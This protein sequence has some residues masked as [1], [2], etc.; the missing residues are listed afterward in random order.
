MEN[1]VFTRKVSKGS[2]FNQVYIPKEYE[3]MLEPGDVVEIRLIEKKAAFLSYGKDLVL[4]DYKK[5]L[6]KDIFAFLSK[7]QK[8]E[9]ILVVGSFLTKVIGYN[10]IDIILIKE[11]K[12][13]TNIEKELINTFNQ[14]FHL[15]IYSNNELISLIKKCPVTRTMLSN[16]VSYKQPDFSNEKLIDEKYL[17]FLLMMPED[18]LSIDVPADV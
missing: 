2:M 4:S 6:I 10:D 12:T 16:Y 9:N 8:P 15:L 18:I 17:K 3:K 1:L 11:D 13:D 14:R 5:N 7:T